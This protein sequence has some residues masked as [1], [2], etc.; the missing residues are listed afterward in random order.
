[1]TL[2][3]HF[4]TAFLFFNQTLWSVREGFLISTH[5]LKP[6]TTVSNQ[7]RQVFL[8]YVITQSFILYADDLVQHIFPYLLPR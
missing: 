6:I 2:Y 1:M 7:G 5:Q 3:L 4:T 8:S